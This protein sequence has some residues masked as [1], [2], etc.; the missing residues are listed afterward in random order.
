MI[1]AERKN[2]DSVYF[3]PWEGS[4]YAQG[5][6]GCKVLLVGESCYTWEDE[7]GLTQVPDAMHA[8]TMIQWHL[9]GNQMHFL[10]NIER[11][12]LAAVPT[13]SSPREFWN[14]V[15]LYEF[16]Q[17][18]M[19]SASHRPT[20]KD[21]RESWAPFQAVAQELSP[22]CVF[23]L[24]YTMWKNLELEQEKEALV[25]SG[26]KELWQCG[27]SFQPGRITPTFRLHHPSRAYRPD[28]WAPCVKKALELASVAVC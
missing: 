16:V 24:G 21:W 9:H 2:P 20:A 6:A 5:I 25:F 8:L 17:R 18:P 27:Y 26:D 4:N 13:L 7:E 12:F 28:A 10:S 3:T 23:I 22:D 15:A 19:T 1:M 14:S 11:T